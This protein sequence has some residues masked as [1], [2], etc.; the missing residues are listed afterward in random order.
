MEETQQLV[1]LL[2]GI[3]LKH[4]KAALID[5]VDVVLPVAMQAVAKAI[6]GPVDDMVIAAAMPVASEQLKSLIAGLEA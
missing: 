6:P 1:E 3:G 2:K 4:G 5:V